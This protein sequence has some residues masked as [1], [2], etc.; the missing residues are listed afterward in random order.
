MKYSIATI[1]LLSA[2]VLAYVPNPHYK[3]NI[4][5]DVATPCDKDNSIPAETTYLPPAEDLDINYSQP[6]DIPAGDEDLESGEPEYESEIQEDPECEEPLYDS[7]VQVDPESEVPAYDSDVQVDPESEAPTYDSDVQV[8]PIESPCSNSEDDV[9]HHAEVG[10]IET[11][12]F[13]VTDYAYSTETPEMEA[14]QV[15]DSIP[16][17]IPTDSQPSSV[18][19][20]MTIETP[21]YSEEPVVYESSLPYETPTDSEAPLPEYSPETIPEYDS[22]ITM[23]GSRTNTA[24]IVFGLLMLSF[25]S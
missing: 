10:P 23:S 20:T 12:T 15:Y 4:G 19:D 22:S 16:E 3:R 21:T 1:T 18:Y 5:A 9:P 24:S 8:E 6:L 17:D 25:F 13:D 14:P 11:A 7:D 2:S